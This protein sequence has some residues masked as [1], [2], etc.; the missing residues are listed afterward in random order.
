M[1]GLRASTAA[2]S[3]PSEASLGTDAVHE[4]VGVVD[5]LHQRRAS[6]FALEVE[7]G[8]ALA[9]VDAHEDGAHAS[10]G[11]RTGEAR[12]VALGGLDLDDVGAEVGED[13]LA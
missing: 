3:M 8:A 1:R 7:H 13:L 10:F 2:G 11:G 5:Q 6:F 9:A 4:N 12:G